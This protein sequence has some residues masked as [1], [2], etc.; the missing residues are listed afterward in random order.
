[1]M[2]W[3]CAFL[4]IAGGALIIAGALSA[5]NKAYAVIGGADGPTSI[6]IAAKPSP[7]T[8]TVMLVSGIII[9]LVTIIIVVKNRK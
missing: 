8:S 5:G 4:S 3:I 7:I 1:M 9:I 6:F 2:K